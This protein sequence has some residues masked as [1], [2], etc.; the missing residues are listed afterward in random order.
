MFSRW[1]VPFVSCD[2]LLILDRLL[3]HLLFQCHRVYDMNA[4]EISRLPNELLSDIVEVCFEGTLARK[5]WGPM[6]S[7]A[8]D[9]TLYL[10]AWPSPLR[11]VHRAHRAG[12]STGG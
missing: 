7:E 9:L 3:D 1:R 8:A 2:V 11:P 4:A 10:A 6:D 12:W 5:G